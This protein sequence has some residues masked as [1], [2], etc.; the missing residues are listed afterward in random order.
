MWVKLLSI[1]DIFFC[2]AEAP[3]NACNHPFYAF[4]GKQAVI[5]VYVNPDV[6]PAERGRRLARRPAPEKRSQYDAS[7]R[8]ACE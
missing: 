4:F 1:F 7:G 3:S 5:G 8:T 2:T 6:S